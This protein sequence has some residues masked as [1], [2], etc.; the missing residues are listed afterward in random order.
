MSIKTLGS[1]VVLLALFIACYPPIA[2]G[3]RCN[4][5]LSFDECDNAPTVQC[6]MPPNCLE[7]YCCSPTS[8]AASC[9]AC[10]AASGDDASTGDDGA[11]E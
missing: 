10:P 8:T 9:Q 6:V 3:Q 7:A 4:S 1:I 5:A 11:T 2:E